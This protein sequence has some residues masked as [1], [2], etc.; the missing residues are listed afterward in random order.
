[1]IEQVFSEIDRLAALPVGWEFGRGIPARPKA[2]SN[3]RLIAANLLSMRVES[4]EIFPG[5][6]GQI[7]IVADRGAESIEIQCFADGFMDFVGSGA[8]TVEPNLTF[9]EV[10]LRL[11]RLGWRSPTLFASCT[12]D[13]TASKSG[14]LSAQRFRILPEAVSPLSFASALKAEALTNALTL[15][16]FTLRESR[17]P[18][19][20]SGEYRKVTLQR[21][22]A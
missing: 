21:A 4:L 15:N 18:R 9:A 10:L 3:A 12:Q 7:L 1:M 6:D 11:E 16:S 19:R 2:Q 17:M 8:S 13:I 14:D 20:S 5:T 22:V